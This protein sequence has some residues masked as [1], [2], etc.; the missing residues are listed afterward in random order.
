[1]SATSTGVQ[2]N[3]PARLT[4]AALTLSAALLLSACGGGG[5]GSTD[6]GKIKGA[7]VGKGSTEHLYT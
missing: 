4:A 3:R 6:H 1:M 7:D 5:D 2:R